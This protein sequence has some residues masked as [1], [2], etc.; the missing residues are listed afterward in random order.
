M[1][2]LALAILQTH[3]RLFDSIDRRQAG[4]SWTGRGWPVR[5]LTG[6]AFASLDGV[7]QAPGGPTE[8]PTGGFD[9]GGG[10]SGSATRS[11]IP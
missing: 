8:D 6:A 5:K 10:C 11:S 2:R 1:V 9:L 4:M 7:I 3:A